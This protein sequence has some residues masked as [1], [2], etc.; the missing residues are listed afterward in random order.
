MSLW[1]VTLQALNRTA[2]GTV[3][4]VFSRDIGFYVF[5]LP[6]LTAVLGFLYGLALVT[7]LLLVAVY[8]LRGDIIVRPRAVRAERQA[9]STSPSCSRRCCSLRPCS[10]GWWTSANLLYSVHRPL[11]RRQLH[12][13]DGP[14]A[15]PARLGDCGRGRA[16]A[17]APRRAARTP[18]PLHA[19][20]RGRLRDRVGP[21]ARPLPGGDAEVRGWPRP[22]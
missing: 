15:R 5:T 18:P 14:P 16:I 4:P 8:W 21:G 20:R 13:P 10:S 1:D 3:D 6:A 17:G 7:L 2:F 11:D 12:R 22:S 19:P 9:A